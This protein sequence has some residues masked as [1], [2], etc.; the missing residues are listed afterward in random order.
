MWR[1]SLKHGLW[2][3]A[4]RSSMSP[5]FAAYIVERTGGTLH[6][7]W[8]YLREQNR[9]LTQARPYST[10][11]VA[12]SVLCT[13]RGHGSAPTEH[14]YAA[15]ALSIAV[16]KGTSTLSGVSP[17]L[18]TVSLITTV[19]SMSS[20]TLLSSTCKSMSSPNPAPTSAQDKFRRA[21]QRSSRFLPRSLIRLHPRIRTPGGDTSGDG[22]Y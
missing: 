2:S 17:Q 18:P 7:L 11:D 19:S 16:C 8:T 14:T 22:R 21:W 13:I 15:A 10:T 20:L 6:P 12:T 5:T 9:S 1:E 3:P 4:T